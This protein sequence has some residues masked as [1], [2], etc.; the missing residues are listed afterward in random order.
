MKAVLY[1][2]DVSLA[3][4]TIQVDD[5]AKLTTDPQRTPSQPPWTLARYRGASLIR[6]RHPLGPYSRTMTRPLWGPEGG[7]GFLGAMYPY[8]GRTWHAHT[9]V[10]PG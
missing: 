9:S 4:L 3:K 5:L 7:C 8:T 6:K 2:K 1:K 10:Q